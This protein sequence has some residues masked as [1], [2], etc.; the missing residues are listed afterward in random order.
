METVGLTFLNTTGGPGLS[1]AA[2][3]KAR[4]HVTRVNFAKRRER[5]RA[6][7]QQPTPPKEDNE[8]FVCTAESKYQTLLG[9]G[10]QALADFLSP[11]SS[12][13]DWTSSLDL[14]K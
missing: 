14:C 11:K 2:A 1:Q 13:T 7:A 10:D 8:V 12:R 5:Q 9:Q 4:G 6:R 3:R